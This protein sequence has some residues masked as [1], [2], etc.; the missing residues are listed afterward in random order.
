MSQEKKCQEYF[1]LFFYLFIKTP[2]KWIEYK[3][4]LKGVFDPINPLQAPIGGHKLGLNTSP[5]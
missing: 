2:F 3:L 4:Y 1:S 5:Y